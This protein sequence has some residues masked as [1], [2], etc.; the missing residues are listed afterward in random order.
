M[1][2]QQTDIPFEYI[3]IKTTQ[4]RID[5]GLLAIPVSLIDIFPKHSRK[6]TVVS[7]DLD[8]Q[9]KTFTPY[10]SSS[11]ECRIGGMR[12]FYN[13][14]N[15]KHG[16][17]LV[18]QLLND[19][20]FKIIPEKLF[21]QQVKQLEQ[22]LVQ[23]PTEEVSTTLIEKISRVVNKKPFDVIISEYSRLA[24]SEISERKKITKP[25][26]TV[27]EVVPPYLRKILLEIFKGK[28][29][30]TQF[31]FLMKNGIP[32][33]ELHHIDPLKGNHFKN[34]LVVSP[35]VHAQFTYANAN[36]KFD[37]NNWLR[38]VEFNGQMH[39]VYQAIDNIKVEF[40]KDV[41]Q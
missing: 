20:K 40:F 38:Q 10:S 13:K 24:T 16:D 31:T 25:N 37:E 1:Q 30:V 21:T 27:K 34:L 36:Q 26:L 39:S 2:K 12:E 35:N 15:L 14:Y 23:S 41:H 5:K 7:E 6:I 9:P 11:R 18:I 33:F 8:E 28:C 4:S 19:E 32:Y 22:S 29:Q 3:T 17:E